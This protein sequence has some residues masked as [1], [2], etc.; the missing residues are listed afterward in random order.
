MWIALNIVFW[1]WLA[2]VAIGGLCSIPGAWKERKTRIY[3]EKCAREFD[4]WCDREIARVIAEK[5]KDE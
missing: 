4:R 3:K 2:L 1:A 5:R